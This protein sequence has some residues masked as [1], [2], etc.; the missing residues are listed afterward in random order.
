PLVF[1][2]YLGVEMKYPACFGWYSEDDLTCNGQAEKEVLPCPFQD[3]CVALRRLKKG[4]GR[5]LE[6]FIVN[7]GDHCLPLY[8]GLEE[9]L[10]DVIAS[11]G[12]R[13]GRAT[14]SYG[15]SF[16][17]KKGRRKI[18]PRKLTKRDWEKSRT[19]F[20][21]NIRLRRKA[22]REFLLKQFLRRFREISGWRV[23]HVE[24][25]LKG[26][27]YWEDK[28]KGFLAIGYRPFFGTRFWIAKIYPKPLIGCFQFCLRCSLEDIR[29]A[30]YP[31]S[32]SQLEIFEWSKD[33]VFPVRIA[34]ADY[35]AS[36]VVAELLFSA[37]SNGAF[38]N[39]G[40]VMP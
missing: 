26:S 14:R 4:T 22:L 3:R 2:G 25:S 11:R 17:I 18:R 7:D 20:R 13:E 1:H 8:N 40:K 33:K 28:G 36:M 32:I 35:Y 38:V 10:V 21:R 5:N 24:D 29:R 12:I 39:V 9:K 15:N 23:V 34:R 19:S 16:E 37:I 27:L 6:F 31:R 30:V